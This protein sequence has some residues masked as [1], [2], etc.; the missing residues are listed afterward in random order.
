MCETLSAGCALG[1][2]EVSSA[3]DALK[4]AEVSSAQETCRRYQDVE[5]AQRYRVLEMRCMRRDMEI[6]TGAHGRF[7]SRRLFA[8]PPR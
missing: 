6:Y 4:Y 7:P 2:A 3:G 1:N 5:K 8:I